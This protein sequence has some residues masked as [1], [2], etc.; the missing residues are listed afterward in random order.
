MTDLGQALIDAA[1]LGS[2]YALIAV[3]IALVFGVMRLI[4]MAY[5]E[6]IIGS[7]FAGYFVQ[8]NGPVVV[9]VVMLVS[10]AAL[11]VI[12]ELL[13]FKPL[14][15]ADPT[16]MLIASFAVSFILQNGALATIGA[17]PRGVSVGSSL[18]QSVRFGD[19]RIPQYNLLTIVAVV[20]IVIML[21]IFLTKTSVGISMRAASEDFDAARLIGVHANVV[22]RSAFLISGLIAAVVGYLLVAQTG[23]VTPTAGLLPGLLGFVAVVIGG[24][25]SLPAAA[26][27]GVVL[28]VTQVSLQYLLPD[29]LVVY[30]DAFLFLFVLAI[31]ILRPQGLFVRQDAWRSRV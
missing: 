6:I 26:L 27:G 24:M 15:G 25:G 1:G 9:V 29:E 17:A 10:G 31:L 3:G 21:R 28:G 19:F 23:V 16:T 22:I 18:A 2:M 11:A 8:D 4:N 20:V 13:A 5:G 12:T 30:K 14:R 7:I